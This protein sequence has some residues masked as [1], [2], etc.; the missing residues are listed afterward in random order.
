MVKTALS[1]HFAA[2]QMPTQ[3]F[4]WMSSRLHVAC[5]I[6]FQLIYTT[7]DQ[8]GASSHFGKSLALPFFTQFFAFFFFFYKIKTEE[9]SN[10]HNATL[11][12]RFRFWALT[13]WMEF[14]VVFS[15]QMPFI[16]LLTA[17][18]F[19][20]GNEIDWTVS[21][22]QKFWMPVGRGRGTYQQRNMAAQLPVVLEVSSEGLEN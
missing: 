2:K 14:S 10:L 19:H 3:R 4:N 9:H 12:Q 1:W 21:F 17:L 5:A 18:L 16:L 8:S 20:W 6:A 11:L 15:G 13:I 7:T 22:D